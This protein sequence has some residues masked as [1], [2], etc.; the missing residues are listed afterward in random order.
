MHLWE[1]LEPEVVGLGQGVA[2]SVCGPPVR[3]G[4]RDV[5]R[6]EQ[7]HSTRRSRTIQIGGLACACARDLEPAKA[8]PGYGKAPL[9]MRRQFSSGRRGNRR[10]ERSAWP[11]ARCAPVQS[12]AEAGLVLAV[13]DPEAVL[14]VAQGPVG[15]GVVAQGRAPGLDGSRSARRACASARAFRMCGLEAAGGLEGRDAGAVQGLADIDVARLATT[16]WSSS[17]VMGPC[18][19]SANA[20]D[21]ASWRR[22]RGD[23]GSGPRVPQ[24]T[25]GAQGRSVWI[26]ST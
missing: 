1:A 6:A 13:I 9:N 17:R 22:R 3:P 21:E 24:T 16:R 25:D 5:D 11:R 8:G 7:H 14:E 23:R 19:R 18:L 10:S 26:R 20:V 2:P 4:G 15:G 12:G